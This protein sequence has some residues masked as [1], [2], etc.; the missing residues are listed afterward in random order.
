MG[1]GP[2]TNVE[3]VT[4]LMEFSPTG[5][6]MQAFVITAIE[7]YSQMVLAMPQE[8]RNR[9]DRGLISYAVWEKCASQ[10]LVAVTER[11]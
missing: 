11:R 3:L 4:R 7:K 6:M 9:M 5:A 8:Q 1:E 10:A 2:E